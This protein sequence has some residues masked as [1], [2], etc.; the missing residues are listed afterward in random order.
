MHSLAIIIHFILN[1]WMFHPFHVSVC[2]VDYNENKKTLQITQKIFIDDLEKGIHNTYN[3]NID[4]TLSENKDEL[5]RLLKHYYS[6]NLTIVV[7]EK[8]MQYNYL[9]FEFE[10]DA[11]WCYLEIEKVKKVKSLKI[12]NT[13]LFDIFDDQSTILHIQNEDDIKSFRLTNDEKTATL[14]FS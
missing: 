2:E 10:E 7:N 4:I 9:G 6:K 12:T 3:N 13:I 14:A 1:T 5:N 11:L 8:E